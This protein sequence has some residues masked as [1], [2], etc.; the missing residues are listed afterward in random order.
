MSAEFI[1]PDDPTLVRLELLGNIARACRLALAEF[2]QADEVVLNIQAR[3]EGV[4]V[5][6]QLLVNG[7]PVGGWG[8]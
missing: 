2:E 8:C 5:D 7:L 6:C 1:P 4:E 3:A